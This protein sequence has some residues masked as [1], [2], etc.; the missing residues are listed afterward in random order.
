[1]ALRLKS[2]L[3][4]EKKPQINIDNI[5]HIF[6][7]P[8]PKKKTKKTTQVSNEEVG[9]N[10]TVDIHIEETIQPLQTE[11]ELQQDPELKDRIKQ[12]YDH[13]TVT[14]SD[15]IVEYMGCEG[16]PFQLS[17]PFRKENT[18]GRHFFAVLNGQRTGQI[19]VGTEHGHTVIDNHRT[20]VNF[21]GLN[22]YFGAFTEDGTKWYSLDNKGTLGKATLLCKDTVIVGG[23]EYYPLGFVF[24][25][26]H[27]DL[28]GNFIVS[29]YNC[30][31]KYDEETKT[32][33]F[34]PPDNTPMIVK[35]E[36]SIQGHFNGIRFLVNDNVVTTGSGHGLSDVFVV[37]CLDRVKVMVQNAGFREIGNCTLKITQIA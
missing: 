8:P 2:K 28:S 22:N 32:F 12:V 23:R 13:Y 15:F 35:F 18:S 34:C 5:E 26:H 21:S 30:C 16:R 36:L 19:Y 25:G 33:I 17:L 37:S 14:D 29:K 20:M 3:N 11:T 9:E 4:V 1:M 10:E 27:T 6:N 31:L 7:I 24:Y